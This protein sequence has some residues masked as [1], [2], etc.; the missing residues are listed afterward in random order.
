MQIVKKQYYDPLT[1]LKVEKLLTTDL[2]VLLPF[3]IFIHQKC[4]AFTCKEQW[5]VLMDIDPSA[6]NPTL[7][8]LT[9]TCPNTDNVDNSIS[10]YHVDDTIITKIN[11]Q[12]P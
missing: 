3:K 11:S 12:C 8:K 5:H 9:Y 7:V 2:D 6:L 10:I 1:E 4:G